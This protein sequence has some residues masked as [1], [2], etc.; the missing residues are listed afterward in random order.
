MIAMDLVIAV[1]CKEN[2]Q[3]LFIKKP[4]CITVM[5]RKLE[6]RPWSEALELYQERGRNDLNDNSSITVWYPYPLA[7][8]VKEK[9]VAIGET[10]K[11]HALEGV[12]MVRVVETFFISW[13]I[14][15]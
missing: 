11:E 13:N 2:P 1:L 10:M 9:H 5:Q 8:L 3:H 12:N 6:L 7:T 4:N 15:Q 14:V